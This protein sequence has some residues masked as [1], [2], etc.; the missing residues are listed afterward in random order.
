MM[1]MRAYEQNIEVQA[2]TGKLTQT[3]PENES[4][5]QICADAIRNHKLTDLPSDMTIIPFESGE[6]LRH[7]LFY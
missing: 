5:I 7:L 2:A 4:R 6:D 3:T 1:I